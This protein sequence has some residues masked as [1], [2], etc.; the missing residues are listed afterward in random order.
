MTPLMWATYNNNPLVT[1]FLLSQGAD[2]EEKDMDGFT[3]MHWCVC[4]CVWG[5]DMFIELD[6]L[7]LAMDR[8][9][10][11]QFS[12]PTKVPAHLMAWERGYSVTE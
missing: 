11:T 12:F 9:S 7:S 2:C 8:N 3:A 1:A 5:G 6:P 10:S 4:V